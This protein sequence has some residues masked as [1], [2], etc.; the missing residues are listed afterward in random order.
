[1]KRVL[2]TN[3]FNQLFAEIEIVRVDAR[4]TEEEA[5]AC[6]KDIIIVLRKD[7]LCV[8]IGEQIKIIRDSDRHQ[9]SFEVVTKKTPPPIDPRYL[10]RD[11]IDTLF[12]N[13]D[14]ML[15]GDDYERV[16]WTISEAYQKLKTTYPNKMEFLLS[17]AAYRIE[18]L[19]GA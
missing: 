18:E 7:H 9:Y 1:M 14:Y 6:C 5:L 10:N 12:N 17:S 16:S 13:P 3:Y 4:V 2:Y 11:E 8:F 15:T 19:V